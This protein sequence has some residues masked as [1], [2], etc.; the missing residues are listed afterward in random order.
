MKLIFAFVML[1]WLFAA[2]KNDPPNQ[3]HHDPNYTDVYICPMDCEKG[4][5]YGQP[6][7]CPVCHM[8]L[9]QKDVKLEDLNR[10]KDST[11]VK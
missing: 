8:D 5:M 7:K 6:G 11:G 10:A 4:K 1:G 2:C 3:L 9:K